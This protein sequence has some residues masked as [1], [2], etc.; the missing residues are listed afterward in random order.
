MSAEA[1]LTMLGSRGHGGFPGMLVG[2]VATAFPPHAASPVEV[3]PATEGSRG[4]GSA[5]D[6]RRV[7]AC[8]DG[9]AA[10]RTV[11]LQA[12]QAAQTLGSGLQIL[13]VMPPPDSIGG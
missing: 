5:G 10:S 11:E 4:G 2:S 9:S 1:Q 7:A 12:A 6:D 13:T 3:V 8:V